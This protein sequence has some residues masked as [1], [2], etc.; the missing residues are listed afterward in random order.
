MM[1]FVS[2]KTL[3]T[4]TQ[5]V[6]STP[7]PQLGEQIWGKDRKRVEQTN[8]VM[9]FKVLQLT[10]IIIYRKSIWELAA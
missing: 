1:M 4:M 8:C 6:C 5:F 10:N 2:C 7:F 9:V 3:N